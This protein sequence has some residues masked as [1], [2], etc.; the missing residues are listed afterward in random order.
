MA[1]ESFRRDSF[2]TFLC[3][4]RALHSIFGERT[5]LIYLVLGFTWFFQEM[6]DASQ[7]HD[8]ELRIRASVKKTG[9]FSPPPFCLV[10]RQVTSLLA[11]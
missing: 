4:T 2:I 3:G 10:T 9:T 8:E 11:F 1:G 7:T 5:T 6:S